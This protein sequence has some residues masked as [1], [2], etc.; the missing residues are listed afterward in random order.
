MQAMPTS[1]SKSG[2]SGGL[3]KPEEPGS[4]PPSN[5]EATV[6]TTRAPM[7]VASASVAA[8]SAGTER[9]GPA[10]AP[11][12]SAEELVPG[13]R[14]LSHEALGRDVHDRGADLLDGPD[15]DAP[16]RV[17]VA[18]AGVGRGLGRGPRGGEQECGG[19]QGERAA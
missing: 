5:Q 2:T 1:G 11:P 7:E 14:A 9:L 3:P 13:A 8:P 6:I 18:P 4:S 16:A 19:G 10:A 17:G 12:G 15:D